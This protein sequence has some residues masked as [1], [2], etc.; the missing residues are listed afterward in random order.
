M[1]FDFQRNTGECEVL[2]AATAARA[3]E[4]VAQAP[5][6]ERLRS[7]LAL[8]AI[9]LCG[10][11]TGGG[12]TTD[13]DDT[14]PGVTGDGSSSTSGTTTS[15]T[16]DPTTGPTT[17]AT[18]DP[19][20]DPTT[21]TATTMDPGTTG[22]DDPG[23]IDAL[24]IGL[25]LATPEQIAIHAPVVGALPADTRVLVRYRPD[26]AADWQVGHPLLRIHPEWTHGEAPVVPV[27]AFAGAIFD[28]TPGTDYD[29]ELTL[30]VPGERAQRQVVHGATRVLPPPA[31][32]ANKTAK[33]SDDLKAVFAGLVPG[34][35]LELADGTYAVDTLQLDVSGTADQPIYIRGASRDGV[36]L[37]DVSGNVLQLLGASHVVIENLTLKGSGTDSGTDAGSHGIS[38]WDGA[39]QEN[40]TIRGVAIVGVDMGI[41]ASGPIR[42]ALVYNSELAGNN[43]WEEA[44]LHSNLTWNDDGVRVPGE[45]NAV[46]ENTLHGFGD[47]FAVAGG[48]HSAAVYFYRNRVTMTG[49]DAFE[50]DYATRNI[51][52]Y[53]NYITNSATFVSFDP[54]YGGPAYVF[55]NVSINTF[56]GPLKL[57]NTNS[58]FMFYNNTM[59]RTEGLTKWGWVQ[60]D[61]GELRNWSY[62]NNLLIYRGGTGSLLAV[63]SS[64]CDPIDFTHNAFYPDGAVWWSHSGASFQTMTD[65]IAGAGQPPTTPVFGDSTL[66]HEYDVVTTNDPFVAPVM[67]GADHL[68]LITESKAPALA[69]GGTAKGAGVAIPN[70]TDGH[71]GT[72]PD[73]G[74][75]IE[76]RP[77]PQ[78]GAKP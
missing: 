8:G 63:E 38:F 18:A 50:G 13:G 37:S 67:L 59:V 58:G 30:E 39:M 20:T 66:R 76:G 35:V 73:I 10:C 49:D 26:G 24:M 33:A 11:G 36:V 44:F 5:V 51:A 56:R 53:D 19:T 74:A 70:V 60:F 61:N 64:G 3:V 15:A 46:F 25:E 9:L 12:A 77:T 43:K 17:S 71:V 40:V 52:F 78:W 65:A 54:I 34:D 1:A 47:S 31:P 42:G 55:R 45:G 32:A 21:G 72:A 48:V 14:T 6:G 75:I 2:E 27:D 62:R 16:A 41:V 68:T 69:P 29:V 57:N 22:P 7:S 28:L 4:P 23:M